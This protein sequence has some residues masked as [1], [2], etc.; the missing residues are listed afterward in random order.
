[1]KIGPGMSVVASSEDLAETGSAPRTSLTP[2]S[3]TV[4]SRLTLPTRLTSRKDMD[5]SQVLTTAR[6]L[7]QRFSARHCQVG[8]SPIQSMTWPTRPCL[9]SNGQLSVLTCLLAK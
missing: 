7:S 6:T 8:V 4:V 9:M 5:A 3:A 2:R 1:M